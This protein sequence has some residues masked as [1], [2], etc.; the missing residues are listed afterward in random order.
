MHIRLPQNAEDFDDTVRPIKQQVAALLIGMTNAEM[1]RDDLIDRIHDSSED[2]NFKARA[3]LLLLNRQG[4]V[5][6]LPS[7][8]YEGP[9]LHRFDRTRD[10]AILACY[11]RGF[12][13]DGHDYAQNRQTESVSI[14]RRLGQWIKYPEITF[15]ASV[16]HTLAWSTLSENF[17]LT[18]RLAAWQDFFEDR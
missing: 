13:R 4:F 11:A 7:G 2:L 15:D 9:H 14:L 16:S 5:Y 8:R 17:L 3:E 6:L 12:L 18:E 1:L 10:L